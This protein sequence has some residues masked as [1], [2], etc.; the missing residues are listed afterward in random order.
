[1]MTTEEGQN[2][3]ISGVMAV[4]LNL[5]AILLTIWLYAAFVRWMFA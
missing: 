2:Y 4:C 5:S 3:S 1:M